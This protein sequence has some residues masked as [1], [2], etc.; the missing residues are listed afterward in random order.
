MRVYSAG[1]LPRKYSCDHP[2]GINIQS[3]HRRWEKKTGLGRVEGQPD[4]ERKLA[5][6][7]RGIKVSFAAR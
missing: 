1:G 3:T 5:V 4:I 7:G 2:T 6:R